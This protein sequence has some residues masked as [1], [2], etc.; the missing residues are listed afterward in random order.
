MFEAT[1]IIQK[2]IGLS[3]DTS[4]FFRG[5]YFEMRTGGNILGLADK[6]VKDFE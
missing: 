4:L 1:L 3:M 6:L 2:Q 5:S